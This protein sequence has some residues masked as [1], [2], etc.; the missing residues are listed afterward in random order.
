MRV[1]VSIIVNKNK[2][3]LIANFLFEFIN[4]HNYLVLGDYY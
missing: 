4:V 3:R 2:K 1:Y